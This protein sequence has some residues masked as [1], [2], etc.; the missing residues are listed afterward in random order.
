MTFMRTKSGVSNLRLFFRADA[1]VYVEGKP[2]GSGELNV[3]ADKVFYERLLRRIRPD[4]RF[5]VKCVGNKD[6]VFAYFERLVEGNDAG[7]FV[8]VDRDAYGILSDH[9]PHEKVVLTYGYSWESDL[10]TVETAELVI[11]ALTARLGRFSERDLSSIR[12]GERRLKYLCAM[13]FAVRVVGEPALLKKNGRACGISFRG[14]RFTPVSQAEIVRF[15][16]KFRY[17]AARNCSVAKAVFRGALGSE[18]ARAIQGHLWESFITSLICS[19]AGRFVGQRRLDR[20]VIRNIALEKIYD[21]L[22]QCIGEARVAYY[23]SAVDL[24]LSS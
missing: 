14:D 15:S 22:E 20:C 6:A 13:D 10:W 24:A 3:C 16:E 19:V 12:L 23:R 1:I 2:G 11:K 5:K 17:S 21:G 9:I 8:V 18:A 4:T 7:S